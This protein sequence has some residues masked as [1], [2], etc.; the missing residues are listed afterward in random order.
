MQFSLE[1]LPTEKPSSSLAAGGS[2]G[3]DRRS[4]GPDGGGLLSFSSSFSLINWSAT[5]WNPI[6]LLIP[7]TK[8]PSCVIPLNQYLLILTTHSSIHD[9]AHSPLNQRQLKFLNPCS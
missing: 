1:I 7:P 2:A 5:H 6:L 8:P 9:D 4:A 3:P